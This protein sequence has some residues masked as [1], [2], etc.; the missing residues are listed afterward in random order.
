MD[1]A[2]DRP[3][4]PEQRQGDEDGADVGER[5]AELGLCSAVVARGEGV[6]DAVDAGDQE[7]DGGEEAEAWG[8]VQE[9]DMGGGEAIAVAEDGLEV[10]VEAVVCAED[11]GLVDGHCEHDWLREE[12][13]ERPVHAR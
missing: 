6:V 11:D 3:R 8:E 13:L 2:L 10:G 9:A 7:P 4:E 1:V 12:D 5:E